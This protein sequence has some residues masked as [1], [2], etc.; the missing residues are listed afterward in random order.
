MSKFRASQR[1]EKAD[2]E[3]VES[4]KLISHE[5]A[6]IWAQGHDLQRNCPHF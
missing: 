5:N 3:S 1:V 6:E 2:F 4:S